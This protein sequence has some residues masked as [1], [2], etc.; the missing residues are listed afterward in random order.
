MGVE[1][2]REGVG[3]RLVVQGYSLFSVMGRQL[4]AL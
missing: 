1:A 3:G 4:T 2:C